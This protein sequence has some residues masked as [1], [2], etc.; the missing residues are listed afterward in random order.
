VSLSHA[1]AAS[2]IDCIHMMIYTM[3]NSDRDSLLGHM[4]TTTAATST[5]SA[6]TS[7][8]VGGILPAMLKERD[9]TRVM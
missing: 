4:S 2:D 3:D 1:Y 9:L 5:A 6:T 7:T 8:S